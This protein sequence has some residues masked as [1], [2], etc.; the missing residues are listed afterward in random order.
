M[1]RPAVLVTGSAV[2]IGR[3]LVLALAR[4]GHDV[5]IH[6]N[7]SNDAADE[8]AEACRKWGVLAE[9]FSHDLSDAAGID[10]LVGAVHDRMPHLG[11][12]VNCASAYQEA[13]IMASTVETYDHQAAVNLRAP[14]FLT[15]AFAR[16]VDKGLVVNILDN[17]IG[18]HQYPYAAYLLP[19]FGLETFTKMA[20]LELAPGI[21]VNA[22]SPGIVMPGQTRSRRYIAWRTQTIP[23]GHTGTV[24]DLYRGLRFLLDSP[25]V[26]GQ[27]LTID[28]G[29]NINHV[30][31]NA[32]DFDPDGV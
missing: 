17:K 16:R 3:G 7:R 6:Y 20:A 8:T 11:C 13:S 23:A 24:E 27:V 25:F 32:T 22:I 5:A 14:F 4:D 28:G 12:L 26:T 31:R 30:G 21:R 18:F 19:K 1:T 10:G 9:T 29:E 2:R 15:Q